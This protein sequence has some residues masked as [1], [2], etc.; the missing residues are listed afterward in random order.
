MWQKLIFEIYSNKLNID[1]NE[2]ISELNET[3][4]NNNTI[5]QYR[6]AEIE[7]IF[8][9]PTQKSNLIIEIEKSISEN[10]FETTANRFS[11]SSTSINGGDL[12]WISSSGLSEELL[13]I[14]SK[15]K[16]GE[17]SKAIIQVNKII[18]LK[19][20]D[21]RNIKN[22]EKM[23]IEKLKLSLVNKKRNELLKLYSNNH[24]SKKEIVL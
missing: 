4:K 16:L 9:T 23:D 21:K 11:S 12:G 24:L 1:E 20:L 10:G 6:L 14:L 13:K 15:L 3:I 19:L 5:E 2:I 17:N 8:D 22:N 7:A 18:F